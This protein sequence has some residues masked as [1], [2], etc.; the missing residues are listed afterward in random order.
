MCNCQ[1]QRNVA[2]VTAESNERTNGERERERER[3][4]ICEFD[5]SITKE[6]KEEE[7]LLKL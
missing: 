4:R 7:V 5:E 1:Q 2:C 6:E 3:E